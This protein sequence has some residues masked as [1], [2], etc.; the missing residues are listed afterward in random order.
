M[1]DARSRSVKTMHLE[2]RAGNEAATLYGQAGFTQ[3][4]RRKDYYHGADGQIF[5][6]LTFS[7]AL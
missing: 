1:L 3:V 2:V 4:N 7:R 5:D 6:A